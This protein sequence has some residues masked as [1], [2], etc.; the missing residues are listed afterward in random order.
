MI[1]D[2]VLLNLRTY[3]IPKPVKL[4]QNRQEA[5]KSATNFAQYQSIANRNIFSFDGTMPDTLASLKA[6]EQS[7]EG[8]GGADNVPVP[9]ALPLTLIGTLVH[10]NPEKSI[11]NIE[12]KSKNL[13]LA[14]RN[15][16]RIDT[17]AKLEAVERGKIIIRNL[18]NNRLEYAEL[19]EV[20][21]LSFSAAKTAVGDADIKQVAPNKYELKRS[22]VDRYTADLQNVLQQAAMVPVRGPGGE[23]TGFRFVNIQNDSIYTKLGLQVGD[24]IKKINGEPID[25][26]QK[27]LELYGALKGASTIS[28]TSERDGREQTTDYNIK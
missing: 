4:G 11:A 5:L 23:V 24:V 12:I 17:I 21:K 26:P 25:S 8:A 20:S 22:D 13:S 6:K 27:A 18:N 9:T 15:G 19:K 1:A 14:V 28:V 10:S 3:M 16:N 2:I 7:G